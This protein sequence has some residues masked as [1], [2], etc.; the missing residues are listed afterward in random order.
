ML[1][2]D[3]VDHRVLWELRPTGRLFE[4]RFD[5]KGKRIW[6]H[7]SENSYDGNE[8][9]VRDLRGVEVTKFNLADFPA[10]SKP[11]VWRIGSTK[12]TMTTHGLY[13]RDA[14]GEAHLLTQNEWC[15][16]YCVTQDGRYVAATTWDGELIVWRRENQQEVFRKKLARAY[17]YLA[18]DPKKNQ[19]LIGDTTLDGT[20]WVRSLVM[21][22]STP[23]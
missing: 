9:T 6:V 1:L 18:Y 11:N 23:R 8:G 21:P 16:N 15:D 22:S 19:I 7:T 4:A 5:R 17:G 3:T 10:E 13:C 12:E 14:R 2:I 20:T